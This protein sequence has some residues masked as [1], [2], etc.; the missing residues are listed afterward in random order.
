MT[1]EDV[2]Y[3][4]GTQKMFEQFLTQ[5]SL[6]GDYVLRHKDGSPVPVRYHAFVFPDGCKAARWDPI[7]DWRNLYFAALLEVDESAATKCQ[8]TM[9]DLVADFGKQP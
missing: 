7:N 4:D 2:S 8:I 6:E 5:G 9:T 1:I 3:Q